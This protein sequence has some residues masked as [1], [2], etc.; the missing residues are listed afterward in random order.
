MKQCLV[1]FVLI[2]VLIVV[3]VV[4]WFLMWLCLFQPKSFGKVLFNEVINHLNIKESTHEYFD[5]EYL[6]GEKNTVSTDVHFYGISM[7]KRYT[8]AY[9]IHVLV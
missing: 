2:Y 9:I 7:F 3:T 4:M 8:H 1:K 5:L 6:D